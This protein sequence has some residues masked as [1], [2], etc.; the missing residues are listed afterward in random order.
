M[1]NGGT[2]KVGNC[3]S[4]MEKWMGRKARFP[5]SWVPAHNPPWS[6]SQPS[7]WCSLPV[8]PLG[9]SFV[10]SLPPLWLGAIRESNVN[11][12]SPRVSRDSPSGRES[13]RHVKDQTLI[14][15]FFWMWKPFPTES[16][17]IRVLCLIY[18][19]ALSLEAERPA[20]TDCNFFHCFIS[21]LLCF[22]FGT[23]FS[24]KSSICICHR[25]YAS[26]KPVGKSKPV[27]WHQC[28]TDL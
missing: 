14:C 15:L 17:H 20:I 19:F 12:I 10:H 28:F 1:R 4:K 6:T 8:N 25:K 21:S 13:F 18:L 2:E 27:I 22:G 23:H 7:P 16:T 24:E 3:L 11:E 26:P 9:Y 5:G